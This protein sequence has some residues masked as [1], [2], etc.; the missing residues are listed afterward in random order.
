MAQLVKNLPANSGDAGM[1]VKALHQE[2]P[3]EKEMATHSSTLAWKFSLTGEPGRLQ[4]MGLKRVG[5]D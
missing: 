2:D 3:L 1:G 4:S 5:H